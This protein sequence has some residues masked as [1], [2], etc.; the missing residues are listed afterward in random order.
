MM[1]HEI[2]TPLN[3]VLGI[4]NLLREERLTSEQHALIDTARA[5]GKSLLSVL[6]DI[7]DFSK[8]EAGR[9]VLDREVFQPAELVE[10]S[11]I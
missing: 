1:S 8:L 10:A 7:L 5:S 4:L 2:R 9:M 3:G 11:G 6:N